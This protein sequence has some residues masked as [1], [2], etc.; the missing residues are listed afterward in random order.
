MLR[1]LLL[2]LVLAL[3]P[4]LTQ[5]APPCM[6]GLYGTQVGNAD[7]ARTDD[8]WHANF[9]CR[10]ADGR[11]VPVV[12]ACVHGSCMPIGTFVD[13]VTTLKR[14]ESPV[15]TLKAAW[16]AEFGNKCETATGPLK[17]VCDAAYV[18]ARENFPR[19]VA[20]PA[21]DA[22]AELWQIAPSTSGTRPSRKVVNAALITMSSAVYL[23]AGTACA[24]ST[25]PTFATTAGTWMAVQGQPPELRWLCRKK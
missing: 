21:P 19:G 9:Y 22:P 12:L 23:P 5:A 16:D 3:S 11:V 10:G 14:G 4:V 20:A 2:L 13:R 25:T 15:E 8:G 24:V 7:Y 18:A 1:R 17:S 6:P